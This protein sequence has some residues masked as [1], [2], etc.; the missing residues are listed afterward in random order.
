MSVAEANHAIWLLARLPAERVALPPLLADAFTLRDRLGAY[1]ALYVALAARRQA[2][3]ITLD[4]RLAR[5]ARGVAE[6]VLIA[7]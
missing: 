1:H 4:A 7:P 6:I 2:R 5:A 3:I